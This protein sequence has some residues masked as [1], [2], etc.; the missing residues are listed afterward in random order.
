MDDT[1]FIKWDDRFSVGIKVIDD[2]HKELARLTNELY[3]GCL[4]GDETAREYFMSIIRATVEYTKYHFSAEEEIMSKV[5]Y[6]VIGEHKK[7]HESFIKKILN[8]VQDF[9]DGKKFVPINFVRYLRDWILSHIAVMD[10]Q[11]GF[12]IAERKKM[13]SSDLLIAGETSKKI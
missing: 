6:P 13:G 8:D 9:Q 3:Q 2:Q 4:G 1:P 7:A 5:Q 12:Y 10:K 11:F